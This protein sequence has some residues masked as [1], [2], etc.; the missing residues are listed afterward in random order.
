MFELGKK[1][2]LFIVKEVDFGVYLADNPD[3]NAEERVLLPKKQIPEGKGIGDELEVF[4]Y[5]DSKDRLIATTNS[6]LLS[7]GEVGTLKVSQVTPIGAFLD[8]GLEKDILLPYKEQ[9]RRVKEGEEILVTIYIDKSSR[10]AATM[11]VYERLSCE[12]GYQKDDRVS[13][14][15]YQIIDNFGAFVAVDNKYSA[16][17]PTREM[18]GDISVGDTIEARV[19]NVKPDGKLDLSVREKAHIQM[20]KDAERIMELFDKY[21]GKL[22]FTDKASPE[23]IKR[24]TGMSKNEFKRAIGNLLKN[25][26]VMI[27]HDCIRKMVPSDL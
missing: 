27:D 10:L 25:N 19:T 21:D 2:S 22:P 23:L 14:I 1:Q 9:T 16:L 8:W 15:V 18:F 20:K 13:G 26:M 4:L 11:N 17:I 7:V 3:I 12:S 6:P 24:E 5:K